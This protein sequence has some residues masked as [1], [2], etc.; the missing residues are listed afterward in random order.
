MFSVYC[1]FSAFLS[2]SISSKCLKDP[3]SQSLLWWSF[4]PF[5]NDIILEYKEEKKPRKKI[6]AKNGSCA[7]G[8]VFTFVFSLLQ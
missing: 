3:N 4:R 1:L 5:E 2:I 8:L 7:E 6:E